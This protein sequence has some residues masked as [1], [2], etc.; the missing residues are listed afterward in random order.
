MD[1][2]K[3]NHLSIL[4][5]VFLAVSSLFGGG[6]IPSFGAAANVTTN[7]NPQVFNAT[8]TLADTVS[9][10]NPGICI[11]VYATSTATAGRMVASTTATIEGVDGVMMFAYGACTN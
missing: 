3:Q 11:N 1:Y 6:A 5:I 8:T 7:T 2:L 10:T 9:F 4:V